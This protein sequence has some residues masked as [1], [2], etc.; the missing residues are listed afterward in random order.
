MLLI[1]GDDDDG[2]V[3]VDDDYIFIGG[4]EGGVRAQSFLLTRKLT[5]QDNYITTIV[6]NIY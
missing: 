3:V 2:D 4:G 6:G 5:N 1:V